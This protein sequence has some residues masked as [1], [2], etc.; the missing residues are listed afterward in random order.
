MHQE[1]WRQRPGFRQKK[2]RMNSSTAFILYIV[3][4]PSLNRCHVLKYGAG[5]KSRTRDLL[6]TNQ[7]L[8]Q[9]SYAGSAVESRC[10]T[11][12]SSEYISSTGNRIRE[13]RPGRYEQTP[14]TGISPV[15]GACR[16]CFPARGSTLPTGSEPDRRLGSVRRHCGDARVLPT[17]LFPAP[18][19]SSGRQ[20][21]PC[22]GCH[23]PMI[24][25][26]NSRRSR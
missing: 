22:A 24:R 17:P 2:R 12:V 11:I 8:Y 4:R 7:L 23:P 10:D 18:M 16:T 15:P 6:I 5:T 13:A 1:G 14:G 19:V 20:A 26:G 21:P 3:Q 25:F 9:L